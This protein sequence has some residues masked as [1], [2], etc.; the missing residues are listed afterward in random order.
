MIIWAD[1]T[2]QTAESSNLH[3]KSLAASC[4]ACHGTNGNSAGRTPSISSIYKPTFVAQM[5]AYRSGERPATVMQRHA[6]GLTVQE[7]EGLAEY[8]S[9]QARQQV[10]VIPSQNLSQDFPN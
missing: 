8:F 7:I 10:K 4:A 9:K 3:I 1:E 6:K 5:L 2:K